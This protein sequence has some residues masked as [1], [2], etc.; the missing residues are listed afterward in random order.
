MKIDLR[1]AYDIVSW[2]FIEEALIG[3][4]YLISFIELIM[5][6]IKSTKFSVKVNRVG[7]GYFEGKRVLRQGDSISPL[8]FV[9]VKFHPMCKN[10]K[11]SHLIFVDDL[12]IFCKGDIQSI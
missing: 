10:L 7:Y 8:L 1:K 11:L 2:D 5:V 12:M 9:L 6:C 3:Y 4:G